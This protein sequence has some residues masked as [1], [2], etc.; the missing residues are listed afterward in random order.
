MYLLSDI[1]SV[2]V[3]IFFDSVE[4]PIKFFMKYFCIT[5]RFTVCMLHN[6][7]TGLMPKQANILIKRLAYD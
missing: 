3:C 6:N 4:S 7:A 2:T 1:I 5:E